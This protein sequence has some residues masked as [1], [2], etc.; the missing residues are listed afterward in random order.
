MHWNEKILLYMMFISVKNHTYYLRRKEN[1]GLIYPPIDRS[2]PL[3]APVISYIID[4]PPTNP[5]LLK[6]IANEQFRQMLF[7]NVINLPSNCLNLGE[8]KLLWKA[9]I[10]I[11]RVCMTRTCESNASFTVQDVKGKKKV[12][13]RCQIACIHKEVRMY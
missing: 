7:I 13:T 2:G 1:S 4:K 10:C 3:R 6:I 11:K 12:S 8:G 5:F 9:T